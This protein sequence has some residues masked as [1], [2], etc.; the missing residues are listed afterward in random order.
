MISVKKQPYLPKPIN[1]TPYIPSIHSLP[2]LKERK[3][4]KQ[5]ISNPSDVLLE[6]KRSI[7]KNL[8]NPSSFDY[9]IKPQG[10]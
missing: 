6:P 8:S 4:Q 10:I 3:T 9:D 1:Y 5:S 7:L 2:K